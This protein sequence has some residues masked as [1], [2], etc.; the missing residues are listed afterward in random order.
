MTREKWEK[1]GEKKGEKRNIIREIDRIQAL[2]SKG[3]FTDS[4]YNELI[5]PLEKE[6]AMLESTST[7]DIEHDETGAAAVS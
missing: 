2:Y 3:I 1:R 4:A 6:L 5:A 7:R